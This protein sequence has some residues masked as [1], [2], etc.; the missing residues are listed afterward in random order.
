MCTSLQH[1]NKGIESSL[2]FHSEFLYYYYCKMD[3][4][5]FNFRGASNQKDFKHDKL[6]N[7]FISEDLN[8]F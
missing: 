2:H 6:T 1:D 7:I 8:V 3:M 5:F 4:L